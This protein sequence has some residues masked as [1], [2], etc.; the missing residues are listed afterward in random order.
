MVDCN[1]KT[2]YATE[3]KSMCIC[4]EAACCTESQ[5]SL[6]DIFKYGSINLWFNK[7]EI[8]FVSLLWD[9]RTGCLKLWQNGWMNFAFQ[10]SVF[11]WVF[12]SLCVCVCLGA[13][14]PVCRMVKAALPVIDVFLSHQEFFF[15]LISPYGGETAGLYIMLRERVRAVRSRYGGISLQCCF[16]LDLLTEKNVSHYFDDWN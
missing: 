3:S 10:L 15:I 8:N 13:V 9:L 1:L 14:F 12:H 5:K 6:F 7:S 2:N 4:A 11:K 16:I